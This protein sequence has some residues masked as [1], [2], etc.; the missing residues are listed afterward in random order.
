MKNKN[1]LKN[2]E[3]TKIISYHTNTLYNEPR[4]YEIPDICIFHGVNTRY[5]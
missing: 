5:N 3:L 2:K 1:I 4:Y